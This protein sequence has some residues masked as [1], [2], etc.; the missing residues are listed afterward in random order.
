MFQDA[1]VALGFAVGGI[2]RE[3]TPYSV[4]ALA[5]SGGSGTDTYEMIHEHH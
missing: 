3:M 1:P 4:F 2:L 5:R